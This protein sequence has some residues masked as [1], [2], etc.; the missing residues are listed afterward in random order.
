VGLVP[1]VEFGLQA[2]AFGQQGQIFRGQVGH[3]GV[4]AAP[5]AHTGHT[6]A[7]QNLLVYE[8]VKRGGNLESVNRG[9]SSHCLSNEKK[10]I[11]KQKAINGLA[12]IVENGNSPVLRQARLV[13]WANAFGST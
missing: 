2:V 12:T 6:C 1:S 9:A 4:K 8:L 5:E 13:E 10:Q 3:D 7:R 11:K